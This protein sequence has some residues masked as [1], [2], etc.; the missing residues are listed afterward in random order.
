MWRY[1][2][3]VRR[4]DADSV[5]LSYLLELP[6]RESDWGRILGTHL[7]LRRCLLAFSPAELKVLQLGAYWLEPSGLDVDI[8]PL[9]NLGPGDERLAPS[10]NV[11]AKS[12]VL[13][14]DLQ[15]YTSLWDARRDTPGPQLRKVGRLAE[16]DA[17]ASVSW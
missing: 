17:P 3:L 4:G 7:A 8:R 15:I 16:P 10:R 1:L 12:A 14:N 9:E 13:A 2:H 6:A 5:Q 11:L